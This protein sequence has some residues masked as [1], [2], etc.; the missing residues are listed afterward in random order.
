MAQ[1]KNR[2]I[3]KRRFNARDAKD[4]KDADVLLVAAIALRIFVN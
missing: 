1:N 3:L 2:Q 4:A